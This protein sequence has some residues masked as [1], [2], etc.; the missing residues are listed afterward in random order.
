VLART[1]VAFISV[2]HA[3]S[4]FWILYA[5]RRSNFL[6]KIFG[7]PALEQH[8]GQFAFTRKEITALIKRY[9]SN[10]EINYVN[11]RMGFFY[12]FPF[13]RSR[14][15]SGANFPGLQRQERSLGEKVYKLNM[16]GEFMFDAILA[17]FP[18]FISPTLYVIIK[19]E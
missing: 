19:N 2:P 15:L 16:A 4:I 10:F 1:G 18:R 13:F 9:F 6:R 14:E 5:L 17:A 3:G 11:C 12:I 7:K 8:V